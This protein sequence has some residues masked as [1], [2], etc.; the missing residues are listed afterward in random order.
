[1]TSRDRVSVKTNDDNYINNEDYKNNSPHTYTCE[2]KA[3]ARIK[4]C[5]TYSFIIF[6]EICPSTLKA[7]AE[8]LFGAFSLLLYLQLKQAKRELSKIG[9]EESKTLSFGK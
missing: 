8:R 4:K 7:Q 9:N 5:G 6:P 3:A 1:M 2:V